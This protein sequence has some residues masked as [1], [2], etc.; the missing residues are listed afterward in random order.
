LALVFFLVPLAAMSQS[1]EEIDALLSRLVESDPAKMAAEV[2]EMQTSLANL[3]AESANLRSKA[4]ELEAQSTAINAQIEAASATLRSL[5]SA[6][7]KPAEPEVQQQMAPEQTPEG[8]Q[9]AGGEAAA[10]AVEVISYNTHIRPIFEAQCMR[11]HNNNKAR[12]GLSLETMAKVLEGGSSGPILVPGN[13]D[14]SRLMALLNWTEEPAMPPSGDQLP[15]ETLDLIRKWIAQGAPESDDSEI[16]LADTKPKAEV[17]VFIAA[18]MTEGPPPMPEAQLA[19]AKSLPGGHE[20]VARALAVNPR[21][22][23]LAVGSYRQILLYNLETETWLGALEFPEGEIQTMTFSVN[24]EVLLAAGGMPGDK[25]IAVLWDVRKAER[26][27]EYGKAYDTLLAADISPDHRMIAVGGPDRVVRV[28]STETGDQ[29]Y[30]LTEHTEWIL[31]LK[32]T[33]D[34]EVLASG[35]RGGGLY[36]WQAANGRPVETLAGHEGAVNALAYTRDSTLLASAGE[37][38]SVQV[39]DTWKYTRVR[40]MNAHNGAVL[41]V[42]YNDQN[43]LVTTGAD[44]VTKLWQADGSEAKAFEPLADWGYQAR[45]DPLHGRVLAGSWDGEIAFWKLDSGERVATLTTEPASPADAVVARVPEV[46]PTP[47]N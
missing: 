11:C 21:S 27:G 29:L 23:L 25:G 7:F 4:D 22:P 42:D 40:K 1:A 34:G 30:E 10:Q 13:P 32:F 16:L 12:S 5:F 37:D 9:M 33:P 35:D 2:Q 19:A 39:W 20:A 44:K 15:Q 14:G 46:S 17:P 3:Q 18:E 6:A 47:T 41:S 38:G 26:I 45:F 43:Q 24:G 31:S 8:I 36:L 28:F